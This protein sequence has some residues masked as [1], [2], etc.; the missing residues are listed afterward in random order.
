[1]RSSVRRRP[2]QDRSYM[3]LLHQRGPPISFSPHHPVSPDS[4]ST[5]NGNDV[6]I[7]HYYGEDSNGSGYEVPV[8]YSIGSGYELPGNNSTYEVPV[9]YS[10]GSEYEVSIGHWM[11]GRIYEEINDP[12]ETYEDVQEP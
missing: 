3:H 8:D 1:M 5:T 6:H 4:S 2:E 12:E 9:N 11:H 10:A 7:R